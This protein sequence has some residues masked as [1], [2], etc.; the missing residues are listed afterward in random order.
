MTIAH[1]NIKRFHIDGEIYDESAIPRLRE[2]YIFMLTMMM[3]SKGYLIRYDIDPDF[4]ISYNGKGFDFILS[5]Y[6]IFVGKKK[7]QWFDGVDKNRFIANSIQ[8]SKSEEHSWPA[9]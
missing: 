5:V 1:R 7:A 4:T 3:K 9:A 8:K 6:G 2:Q